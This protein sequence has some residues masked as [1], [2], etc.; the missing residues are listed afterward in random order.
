VEKAAASRHWQTRCLRYPPVTRGYDEQR[1]V[2]DFFAH[3]TEHTVIA[4][5]TCST[6]THE[7][8]EKSTDSA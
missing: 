8:L 7:D 1:L 4:E 5:H 3:Q 6:L 2:M